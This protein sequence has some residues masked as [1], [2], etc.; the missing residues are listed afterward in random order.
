MAKELM[1]K[2]RL[3]EK[4]RERLNQLAEHYSA[5]AATVVRILVKERV[6]EIARAALSLPKPRK[7]RR[8]EV[9]GRPGKGPERGQPTT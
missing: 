3:D 9:P 6:D 8:E 4:D 1:F 2:M 7:K 5:P